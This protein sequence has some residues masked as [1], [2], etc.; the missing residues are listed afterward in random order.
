MLVQGWAWVADDDTAVI[1]ESSPLQFC[2][3]PDS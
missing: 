2:L 3:M 1:R